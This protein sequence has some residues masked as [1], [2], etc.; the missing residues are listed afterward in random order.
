MSKGLLTGWLGVDYV[1]CDRTLAAASSASRAVCR[2][3]CQYETSVP[4]EASASGSRF[5]AVTKTRATASISSFVG[6]SLSRMS[7]SL[8]RFVYRRLRQTCVRCTI[9]RAAREHSSPP[10]VLSQR[11]IGRSQMTS[12]R[13][14]FNRYDPWYAKVAFGLFLC[15]LVGSLVAL[16]SGIPVVQFVTQ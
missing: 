1:P 3:D 15:V 5:K 12:H 11:V 8:P 9:H 4:G 7:L 14:S 13:Q 10:R 16:Y 6:S 2:H